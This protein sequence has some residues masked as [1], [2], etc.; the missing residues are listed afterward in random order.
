MSR[1]EIVALIACG[2][3]LSF[4][5]LDWLLPGV[6]SRTPARRTMSKNNLK[7]HGLAA[8]NWHEANGRAAPPGMTID[9]EGRPLHGWTT[10][11]LPYLDQG[12]L[13][14]RVD[15]DRPWDDPAHAEVFAESFELCSN[16]GLD[17][18]RRPE[19]LIDYAANVRLLPVRPAEAWA[20]EPVA[21]GG[22]A[23]G[24]ADG[25][26]QTVLFGEITQGRPPWGQPGNLR[27]PAL[28]IGAESG[29]DGPW[30]TSDGAGGCQFA[31]C[32]GGVRFVSASVAPEVLRA[33]ATPAAGDDPGE[34]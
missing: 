3:L 14:N 11:L 31:M 22:A 30:E 2:I 25:L 7:N 4:F 34:W 32:D 12:P 21:E 13:Y 5:A 28:G 1:F 29:F 24:A 16:P 23:M 6:G 20:G 33:F 27:D 18:P 9:A 15:F 19:T 10:F 26:S 8:W 17:G